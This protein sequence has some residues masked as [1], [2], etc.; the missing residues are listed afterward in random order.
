M[1]VLLLWEVAHSNAKQILRKFDK[2]PGSFRV[3]FKDED[4]I[5]ITIQDH[6]DLELAIDTARLHGNGRSDG[7]LDI[8]CEDC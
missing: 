8:W 1:W 7:K 2:R 5:K 6:S 4:G 3:R